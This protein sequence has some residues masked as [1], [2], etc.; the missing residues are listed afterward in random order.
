MILNKPNCIESN[1]SNLSSFCF[2][3]FHILPYVDQDKYT[4]EEIMGY[5]GH[6][7]HLNVRVESI[8]KWGPTMYDWDGVI[9]RGLHN[10]GLVSKNTG[11]SGYHIDVPNVMNNS[12]A[13]IRQS[14]QMG[15]PVIMWEPLGP[16]FGIIY[17]Y[18]DERHS[19][20][21]IDAI[22]E[23]EIPFN[24]I[25]R[26]E[27]TPELYVLSIGE[28]FDISPNERFIGTLDLILKY[29]LSDAHETWEF[30]T[31]LPAYD[32][33]I[34][35]FYNKKIDIY[36]N[37]FNIQILKNAR[38]SA[39]EFLDKVKNE[40]NN[41]QE[42]DLIIQS[43]NFLIEEMDLIIKLEI[44]FPYPG[45]GNPRDEGISIK[46]I[47]LLKEIKDKEKSALLNLKI[48]RDELLN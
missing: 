38:K 1:V 34:N 26:G 31:G 6:A 47:Q 23:G 18:D 35:A 9:P 43:K 41:K 7:F 12:I 46:A 40:F 30:S 8:D 22:R 32:A 17:G 10:L 3:L 19:L 42:M 24:R 48:L 21:V 25:G 29:G 2:C 37:S 15:V 14:I 45:G 28:V 36:G 44:L 39:I 20:Y 13:L 27:D 4:Y 5:T 11:Y 16:E 33:W